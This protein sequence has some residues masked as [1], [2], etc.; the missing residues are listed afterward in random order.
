MH[1]AWHMQSGHCIHP[2]APTC[3]SCLRTTGASP[4]PPPRSKA[5]SSSSTAGRFLALTFPMLIDRRPIPVCDARVLLQGCCGSMEACAALTGAWMCCGAVSD[6]MQLL[7]GPFPAA[8]LR[9]PAV[10]RHL[11]TAVS[12]APSGAPITPRSALQP[13]SSRGKRRRC[14]GW[15]GGGGCVQL[16]PAAAARAA[17][18]GAGRRGAEVQGRL[19]PPPPPPPPAAHALPFRLRSALLPAARLQAPLPPDAGHPGLRVCGHAGGGQP[20][21]RL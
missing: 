12:A 11:R 13:C 7:R 2:V 14:A 20:A 8:V 18:E 3:S 1:T 15:T 5:G 10:P 4:E 16:L 17:A 9:S 19:Q 21:A 6:A